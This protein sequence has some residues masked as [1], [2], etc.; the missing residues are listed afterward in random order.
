MRINGLVRICTTVQSRLERGIRPNELEQFRETVRSTVRTVESLCA[1]SGSTPFDLPSQ[2]RN[3]YLFLKHLNLEE[4]PINSN[5]RQ[6]VARAHVK[7]VVRS[8]TRFSDEMWHTLDDL[9]DSKVV[10]SDFRFGLKVVVDA[11]EAVCIDQGTTI[12]GMPAMSKQSFVW[13]KFLLMDDNLRAHINSLSIGR[14]CALQQGLAVEIHLANMPKSLYNITDRR[15]RLL[16]KAHEGYIHADE[17]VWLHTVK[18][19][20][21]E[22]GISK[23]SVVN[24]ASDARF[25]KTNAQLISMMCGCK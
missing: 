8:A 11:V 2:S 22:S 20:R 13:M 15:D 21:D 17:D 24:F 14:R 5:A 19:M 1:D 12:H 18:L 6:P 4:L 16:I 9:I 3:A 23:R 25:K 7:N 10:F